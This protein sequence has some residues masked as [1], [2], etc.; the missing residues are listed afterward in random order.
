MR[1]WLFLLTIALCTWPL[2]AQPARRTVRVSGTIQAIRSVIVQV[3]RIEGQGGNVTLTRMVS[4]GISVHAGDLLAEFDRTSELKAA[5]EAESKY[6]DLA[7][8]VEQKRAEQKS[9][10]EKRESDL[11]QAQADLKKAEIELRKGPILSDIDKQ[12]HEVEAQDAREHVSSLQRSNGFH[13]Q[14]EAAELRI[15]ELQRDRQKLAVDRAQSNASKLSLRAPISGMVALQNVYRNE[16]MGHAEEGD[17]LWPGS[18]L[19]R[20]FDPSHMAVELSVDEPDGPLL[21]PG[22]K[23]TLHL[24]A[25]PQ[26][27]FTAHFDSASPIATADLGSPIKTFSARFVLDQSDPHLLP[28]LSAAVDIEVPG[29]GPRPAK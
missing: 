16:S 11:Q 14:A 19:M 18:P 4:N 12:K 29:T 22:A 2:L 3:P 27:T 25:F 7:H 15:L 26:L 13:D 5:R 9:N 23:A 1:R 17:Q 21:V 10:R 28:D 6:D 8:Q 24:D 20:I